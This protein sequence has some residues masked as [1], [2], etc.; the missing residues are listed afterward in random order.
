MAKPQKYM[1]RRKCGP[2]HSNDTCP[3]AQQVHLSASISSSDH[4]DNDINDL[5][6]F[7]RIKKDKAYKIYC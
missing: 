1:D 4:W 7:G 6:G 5:L 2:D 3:G